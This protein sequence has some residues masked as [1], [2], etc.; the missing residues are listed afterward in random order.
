[1]STPD[2]DAQDPADPGHAPDPTAESVP[3]VGPMTHVVVP[4]AEDSDVGP[5]AHVVVPDAGDPDVGP[6]AHVVVPDSEVPDVGPV[7]HVVVP[8][9]EV[10]GV[11]PA[12]Y[13]VVPDSEDPATADKPRPIRAKARGADRLFLGLLTGSGSVVL[14]VI[15]AIGTFLGFRA[16]QALKV[17]GFSFFTTQNW[18]PGLGSGPSSF[19]VAGVMV[20]TMLIGVTAILLACPVAFGAALLISEYAPPLLKRV[21]ITLVDLMAAIPS[22]VYGLWGFLYLEVRVDGVAHWLATYF[23]WIP[24]FTVTGTDPR[25]P[26]ASLEQYRNST[27]IAGMIVGLMITP[28]VCSMMRE[29]FSQAPLGERE[30][31]YALGATKWGMIRAVVLPFGRG[32]IIGGAMLGLGRALG[33][34]IAVLMTIT[35]VF[36]IQTH[37]LQNGAGSVSALIATHYSAA[38][39]FELSGLMAAGLALFLVTLVINMV[40]SSII[41]RSRSGQESG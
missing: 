9:T 28:I 8:G 11:G 22:V 5:V 10:P 12:T 40:A 38:E 23:G 24:I 13:V 29:T 21:M 39:S 15:V 33:E 34:T 16:S 20:G 7:A 18:E 27:L 26:L 17:A 30:G 41:A 36:N 3:D 31:A 4:D 35:L 25:S 32:G 6:V 19:G 37:V 2:F 14:V 1:M